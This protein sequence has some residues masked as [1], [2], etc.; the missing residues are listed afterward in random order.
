MVVEEPGLPQ[1]ESQVSITLPIPNQESQT[2]SGAGSHS[3]AH[4]PQASGWPQLEIFTAG[5]T[6]GNSRVYRVQALKSE[7]ADATPSSL[8]TSSL[9][10]PL[11]LA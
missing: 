11:N 1:A 5:G 3:S 9:H 8:H 10:R 7:I 6:A 2:Q 4:R